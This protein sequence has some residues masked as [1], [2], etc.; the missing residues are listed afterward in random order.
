[1]E[2]DITEMTRHGYS[3]LSACRIELVF[4]ATGIRLDAAEVF[5][6]DERG[7]QNMSQV[8]GIQNNGLCP[9]PASGGEGVLE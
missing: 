3:Q 8:H 4:E 9:C 1:M 5:V 6:R 2:S 7:E